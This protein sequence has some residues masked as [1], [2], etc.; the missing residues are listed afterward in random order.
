MDV[1]ALEQL[2]SH[3]PALESVY[4]DREDE[5]VAEVVLDWQALRPGIQLVHD[6][7]GPDLWQTGRSLYGLSV[8][9]TCT[10]GRRRY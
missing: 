1:P 2:G 8:R 3:C 10:S 5:E 4:F 7:R 6:R 9:R